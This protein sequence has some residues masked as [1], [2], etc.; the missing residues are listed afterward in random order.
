MGFLPETM[1]N[2]LLR[3]SW[4]HGDDEIISTEQAIQWFDLDG[5]GKSAA[6]FDLARLT[7]LNA[8]YLR[9]TPDAQLVD[10]IKP[11]LQ[12]EEIPVDSEQ[13][14]RLVAAMPGLKP[15]ATTLVDL[16]AAARFYVAPRPIRPDAKAE[17][18][19]SSEARGLLA[20]L[21]APLEGLNAWDA[22]AIEAELRRQAEITGQKLGNLA[23]P[24]RAA[25]T[26]STASPGLFEVMAVLGRDEVLAR[27]QD[28]AHDRDAAMQL[29]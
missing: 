14:D 18:L 5:V 26:G 27:L 2:Y 3:L 11:L 17:K 22:E 29:K 9:E 13:A 24:M 12:A 21:R 6:R 25:L 19:L 1:R 7:N 4:S 28:L 16:A 8:H 10:L 15:R 23:Q 20:G